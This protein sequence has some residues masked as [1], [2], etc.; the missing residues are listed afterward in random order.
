MLNGILKKVLF[1]LVV[2]IALW[3]GILLFLSMH[4]RTANN[5]ALMLAGYTL[6]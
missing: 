3:T 1:V 6:P 4:L 2:V 5:Y